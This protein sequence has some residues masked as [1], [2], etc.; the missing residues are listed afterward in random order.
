MAKLSEE[1][2]M[3]SVKWVYLCEFFSIMSPGIGRIA[4]A[5]LLLG[6]LPPIK[7]RSRMLWSLIWIQFIVDIATVIISFSQCRPISKF[8]NNSIP[9]SCWPPK[10]QQNTGYFQGGERLFDIL[11]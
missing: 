1:G 8:W 6:L 9:G 5:S 3:H 4:Y 10:V 2:I 11:F 7:W